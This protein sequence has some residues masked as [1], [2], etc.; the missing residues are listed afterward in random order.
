MHIDQEGFHRTC[1]LKLFLKIGFENT[2]NIILVFSEHC[3]C[4]LNLTFSLFFITK[5]CLRI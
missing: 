2:E 5:K 3:S 4:Y 1:F